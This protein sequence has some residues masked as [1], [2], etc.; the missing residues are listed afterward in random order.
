MLVL[1]IKEYITQIFEFHL[2][3][4]KNIYLF[5]WLQKRK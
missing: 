4:A 5:F 2:L 3:Q 1:Q